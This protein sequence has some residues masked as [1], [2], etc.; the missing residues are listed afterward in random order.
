MSLSVSTR[1]DQRQLVNYRAGF[2]DI[3]AI[4]STPVFSIIIYVLVLKGEKL[5]HGLSG[6]IFP[7]FLL[8]TQALFFVASLSL[9]F[10]YG[11]WSLIIC[12]KRILMSPFPCLVW[13]HVLTLPYLYGR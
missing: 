9:L 12:P 11:R 13:L 4:K 8:Y 6:L 5:M 10:I 1:G 3:P 7:V 2:L